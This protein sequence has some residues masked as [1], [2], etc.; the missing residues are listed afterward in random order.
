MGM[1]LSLFTI[2]LSFLIPYLLIGLCDGIHILLSFMLRTVFCYQVLAA[3]SLKD[4]SMTVYH[5]LKK[6][7]MASAR[8]AVSMIVGRDTQSLNE[9]KIIT[10]TVETIAENT[11]DGV[12]APLL[13]L[14]IGGAPLGLAY[15]ALNT[16]DS[17]IG[18]K[19]EKYRYFGK[20]AARL[21]DVANFLPAR[22]S[23]FL[24]MA[25]AFF[26]GS[27]KINPKKGISI[28][29]RDRFNHTS[30]NSAQTEAVYAGLL[31]IRLGG[32]SLYKGIMV[33]KPYIGDDS[34]PVCLEHI[35]LS[36]RIMYL[37]AILALVLFMGLKIMLY[38]ILYPH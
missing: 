9:E 15:K 25:A 3:K 23:A 17:M 11:A 16:L 33:E 30:P 37:T 32:P 35:P 10:A 4:E 20:F 38:F 24:M 12:I 5:Q 7:D 2:S 1:L 13:F 8:H 21:D 34:R 19:N 29:F 26:S 28:F 14:I 31:G 22:I 18:Y 27:D 6:G 36:N